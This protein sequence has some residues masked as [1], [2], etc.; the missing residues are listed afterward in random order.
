MYG[1]DEPKAS[2]SRRKP[3]DSSG[4]KKNEPQPVVA[5]NVAQETRQNFA[6]EDYGPNDYY[7]YSIKKKSTFCL[8]RFMLEKLFRIKKSFLVLL[9]Q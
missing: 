9:F 7:N 3:V 2:P 8:K 1:S 6:Q 5:S 4:M